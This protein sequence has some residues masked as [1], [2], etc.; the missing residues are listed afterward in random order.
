MCIRMHTLVA[1]GVD[2]R[3]YQPD[4]NTK[5]TLAESATPLTTIHSPRSIAFDDIAVAIVP[6]AAP[7]SDG[8]RGRSARALR[9]VDPESRV[10]SSATD[11]DSTGSK[12]VSAPRGHVPQDQ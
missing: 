3:P 8:R 4:L 10:K 9:P 7:T 11:Q 12:C 5:A 2:S 1:L 6:A